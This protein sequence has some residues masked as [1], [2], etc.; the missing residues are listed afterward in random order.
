MEQTILEDILKS[1]TCHRVQCPRL[2]LL[3]E[4][5]VSDQGFMQDQIFA[6]HK[7]G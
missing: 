1:N 6:S 2:K 5:V 7:F 3:T 4:R